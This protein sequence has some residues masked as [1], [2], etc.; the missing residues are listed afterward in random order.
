MLNRA[1]VLGLPIEHSLSPAL[2]RAA[3]DA[4]GL[5]DWTYGRYEVDAPV[6]RDFVESLDDSWR[7]LSLT[8]PLK[9]EALL[10]ARECS[11]TGLETGA[12]NTLVRGPS[13]WLGHNTDV[14]GVVSAL[15]DA[16]V[17]STTPVAD[18][19]L[20]GS[21]AT[22]RSTLAA[23]AQLGC[24]S[25]TMA[26]RSQPRQSALAQARSHG[27]GV[28]VIPLDDAH[29]HLKPVVISTLPPG[30]ADGFST[31]VLAGWARPVPGAVWLD[32]VYAGW[33]TVF[34]LAAGQTGAQVVPGIEMLIHQAARQIELM[35]GHPAPLGAMQE[36]GRSASADR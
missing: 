25:V 28:R 14:H 32:V 12:V 11:A 29:E 1:A 27:L 13:G 35:T 9:E 17:G 8:M 24:R 16:G 33:P 19:L 6:L 31:E 22:A 10:V 30:A 5:T 21:G 23:L 18:A 15:T 4:L 2:H 20:L 34:A 3:Y 36:A 7:G 26:V